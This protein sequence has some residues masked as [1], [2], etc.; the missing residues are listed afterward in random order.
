MKKNKI[1]LPKNPAN[2]KT[3]WFWIGTWSM[4]GEGFGPHDER[5]SVKVL[6]SAAEHNIRHFDTA[7]F[8]AHGKSENLLQKIINKD[9]E[10]GT[11]EKWNTALLPMT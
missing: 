6:H 11:T 3:P 4:G 5:E 1:L 2:T 9:R 8:Y 10:A 7:G